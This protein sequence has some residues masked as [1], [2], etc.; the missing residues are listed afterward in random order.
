MLTGNISPDGRTLAVV[1]RSGLSLRSIE[2]GESHP[3]VLPA[4]FT[5]D[6]PLAQI[7]WFPDGSQLLLSGHLA[8]GRAGVWAL[9]IAGGRTHKLLDD[10]SFAVLSPNGKNI[11]YKRRGEGGSEIWVCGANGENA[12]RVTGDDSSGVIPAW[13]A[14]SPSGRRLAYARG[15]MGMETARLESC[16]LQG[17]T[18]SFFSPP[19]DRP[20]HY[21]TILAWLP[22]GRVVFG[23]TDPPPNQRDMNLW[24]LRVDP[25]SGVPSGSPRRITQWQ[26]LALVV[27][28]AFSTNGTRLSVGVLE[29]HSDVYEGRVAPGGLSL[30]DVRRVTLD[31]RMDMAPTWMP[32]DST[33]VF[34]SDRNGTYDIFRQRMSAT[35]A[36][37]LVTGPGDQYSPHV[38]PDRAW[39]LYAEEDAGEQTR[40]ST[41][42]RLMRIPVAGGPADKVLDVRGIGTF[43]SPETPGSSPVLC[44]VQNGSVVFTAF[45]PVRGR[46]RELSRTEGH[47]QPMWSLSPDGSTIA[48]MAVKEDSIPHIQLLSTSNGPSRDIRLDRPV[49]I[50]DLAYGADGHS[51]LIVEGGEQWHLLHVDSRGR[52]TPL[53]PPQM[54][55]YSAAA[56]PDGKRVAYTSNTGQG[57]IWM[58]EDF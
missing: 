22:D 58:L 7:S 32:D 21:Y 43:R 4:G 29:Y 13:A 51:W 8:D 28:T 26:R 1:D 14:W 47:V 12:I 35:V 27:P 9:P 19:A 34:C 39:I 31:D 23:L 10:A 37:P 36:E 38:S 57:N 45:D 25:N 33:I 48:M 53:I 54:W 52:T 50:A 24:S 41:K 55:M 16:D 20:I 17:R 3:L 11:A 46:G 40:T 30:L 56:S 44:E 49:R 5:F 42:A 6:Y 2:S 18:R 15:N